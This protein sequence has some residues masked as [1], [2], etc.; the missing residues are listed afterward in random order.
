MGD[1][2]PAILHVQF[3]AVTGLLLWSLLLCIKR[4]EL[5]TPVN[6]L[7]LLAIQLDILKKGSLRLDE[8]TVITNCTVRHI[9]TYVHVDIACYCIAGGFKRQKNPYEVMNALSNTPNY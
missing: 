3:A 1:L 5:H 2:K 7:L 4:T 9:M 6:G 8:R